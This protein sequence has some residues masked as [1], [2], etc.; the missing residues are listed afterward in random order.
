VEMAIQRRTIKRAVEA[1]PEKKT[2]YKISLKKDI[3]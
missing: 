1:I 2:K 3:Q